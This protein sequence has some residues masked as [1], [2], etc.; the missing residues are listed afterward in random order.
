MLQHK[1]RLKYFFSFLKGQLLL[2]IIN[3]VTGFFLLRWL[4]ISEQAIFGVAFSFQT[5][6]LSVSD[7]G[8]TGSIIALV[9]TKWNDKIV[10]GSYVAAARKLRS[11]FFGA[12][13]VLSC[14]IIPFIAKKQNW[15]LVQVLEIFTPLLLGVFWQANCS[16]Y[17][18]VLVMHKRL[19]E[20]F[21]PQLIMAG[22]KLV[23]AF[24]LFKIGIISALCIISLNA[25]AYLSNGMTYKRI[26]QQYISIDIENSTHEHIAE[27]FRYIRPLLP[28]IIFNALNGQIQILLIS[29]FGKSTGIAEIAALGKL[30]QFFLF[31]NSFNS[32]VIAPFI[33][34][35]DKTALLKKYLTV[36]IGALCIGG[37]ILVF[38]YFF[39][40]FLKSILG[41]KFTYLNNDYIFLLVLSSTIGYWS[42][43]LWTMSSVLKWVYWWASIS[44]IVIIVLI[45]ILSIAFLNIS[46]TMGVLEMGL[47]VNIGVLLLQ[48]SISMVGFKKGAYV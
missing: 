34:K 4:P 8:F 16:V 13:L 41:K 21:Q 42:V 38:T 10:V 26:A 23:A 28:S 12:S 9:G 18:S 14:I 29:L 47:L 39:P 43:T 37:G 44:Y 6:I 20:L 2:Q 48:L 45:E 32:L 22:V 15:G 5:L 27:I 3:V 19:S 24:L 11:Y 7:L 17:D 40:S 1:N 25:L 36:F 46:T 35:S 30:S 31:F 33:A